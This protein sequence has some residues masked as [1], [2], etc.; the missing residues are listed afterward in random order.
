VAAGISW[1]VLNRDA[2]YISELRKA[3]RVP[4][5]SITSNHEEIG[6]LQGQQLKALL[7]NGGSILH[8]QGQLKV[9]PLSRERQE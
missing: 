6:R 5:L 2:E 7:P 9:W 8:I 4:V 1:V 3:F